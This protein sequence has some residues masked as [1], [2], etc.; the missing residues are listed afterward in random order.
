M[1]KY[2]TVQDK[3]D[4]VE[5]LRLFVG[6]YDCPDGVVVDA[7]DE[8]ERLR[9]IAFYASAMVTTGSGYDQKTINGLG[10]E[11]VDHLRS[12]IEIYEGK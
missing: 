7:A 4:I 12:A 3:A 10:W 1:S 6:S 2:K 9:V 8:I 5:Q 11:V